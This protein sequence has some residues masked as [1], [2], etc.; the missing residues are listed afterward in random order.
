[1]LTYHSDYVVQKLVINGKVYYGGTTDDDDY[2]VYCYDP[3]QDRWTTL[4]PIP[5]RWFGLGQVNGKLVAVG[6]EK[7]STENVS[8]MM[9]TCM[10]K[11]LEG[12]SRPFLPCQQLGIPQVS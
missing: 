9:Y 6:G 5:V 11:D 10:M 2:N 1:M 7:K 4:P 8:I 12:G 3:S